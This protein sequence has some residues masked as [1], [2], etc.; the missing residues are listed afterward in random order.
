MLLIVLHC[1][2]L[3]QQKTFRNASFTWKHQANHVQVSFKAEYYQWLVKVDT[4]HM[5][6][7]IRFFFIIGATIHTGQEIYIASPYAWFKESTTTFKYIYAF[8]S[9]CNLVK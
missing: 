5:T 6:C 4:S 2:I 8:E 9:L 1:K 3:Q 7:V